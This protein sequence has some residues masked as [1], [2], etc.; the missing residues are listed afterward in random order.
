MTYDSNERRQLHAL[1]AHIDTLLA[2]GASLEGRNPL[3]LAIN[4]QTL[5]VRHGTL[6]SDNGKLGRYRNPGENRVE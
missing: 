1:R 3:R 4:G 6:V 5:F 2:A